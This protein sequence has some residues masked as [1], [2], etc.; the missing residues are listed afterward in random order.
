MQEALDEGTDPKKANANVSKVESHARRSANQMK[1][2]FMSVQGALASM[3]LMFGG[4]MIA[5]AFFDVNRQTESLIT[6][7]TVLEG[8]AEGARAVF[9]AIEEFA[10][11]TPYSIE[12][13]TQ[14]FIMLRGLGIRPTEE[15]MTTFGDLAA[16]RGKSI[17]QFAEAVG[18]AATG[19][20]E[21]LK[22]FG[23]KARSEGDKVTFMFREQETTVNKTQGAIVAYLESLGQAEGV[24]GSM[25][26]QSR[27]LNGAISNLF[28]SFSTLAR[29]IGE[30]G[31]VNEGLGDAARGMAEMT[32]RV[33]EN[34]G[35]VRRWVK[36]IFAG[37][38]AI[39]QTIKMPI[40][41]LFNLGQS[42]GNVLEIMAI[43]TTRTVIQM[44]NDVLNRI[45]WMIAQVNRIPGVEI[46]LLNTY[47]AA[48][49][50]LDAGIADANARLK[51]QLADIGDSVVDLGQSYRDF[52]AAV[53]EPITVPVRVEAD[54]AG[55]GDGG[56]GTGGTGGGPG[57]TGKPKKGP[58]ERKKTAA[59]IRK[60]EL[61]A[62]LARGGGAD[63]T[64]ADPGALPDISTGAVS[65][66]NI[67][68]EQRAREN[69]AWNKYFDQVEGFALD[70]SDAIEG[71]WRSAFGAMMEEGATVGNFMEG[72]FRSLSGSALGA[73]AQ[74]AGGKA[75]VAF[76][77][78][79]EALA[80]GIKM[81]GNPL[82]TPFA[83]ANFTAAA[84][85]AGVGALWAGL[86]GGA[87][88]GGSAVAGGGGGRGGRASDPRSSR[89]AGLD[90][91]KQTESQSITYVYVDPFNPSNP[92]HSR[93]IGK[94]VDLNVQLSGKPDWVR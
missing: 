27:T 66:R 42:I 69:V 87:G 56:G 78:A 60:E 6:Q 62:K 16:S 85:Y 94:A 35:Q 49:G 63:T 29:T 70:A 77:E 79:A 82:T 65:R 55:T 80:Q 32:T 84:K 59:Q 30:A 38:K 21:R 73:V 45:N 2:A 17:T 37:T 9:G 71:A 50:R 76:I 43:G 90:Y 40:R 81:L 8:S 3:G 52:A 83:A 23:I 14:S 67:A 39:V 13:L 89:D 54:F 75:R 61:A 28:D 91:A 47:Q 64:V 41:A 33:S 44:V 72:M 7:L 68:D 36:I 1:A 92:V 4:G 19:E 58:K 74:Y 46:G 20:F 10:S 5:K 25:D 12:E 93:Q 24:A 34:E 18:D 51:G 88:V 15:M 48:V 11:K 86:A 53:A 22:E 26:A 57:K 31:G